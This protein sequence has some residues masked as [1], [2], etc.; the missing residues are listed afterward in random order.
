MFLAQ[1]HD[2]KPQS[3]SAK[4]LIGRPEFGSLPFAAHSSDGLNFGLLLQ[5]ASVDLSRMFVRS[6]AG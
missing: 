6:A 2:D 1:S 3:I 5:T 4:V